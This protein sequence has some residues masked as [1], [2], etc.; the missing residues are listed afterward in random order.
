[1]HCHPEPSSSKLAIPFFVTQCF[2]DSILETKLNWLQR[3]E[4]KK[5]LTN[6]KNILK[7]KS[8][9]RLEYLRVQ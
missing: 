2:K 8:S 6:I 3:E 7:L 1:M 5:T 4:K 9:R